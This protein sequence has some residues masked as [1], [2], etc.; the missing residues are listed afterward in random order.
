MENRQPYSRYSKQ[1]KLEAIRRVLDEDQPVQE[2]IQDLGIRHRDNV[3]EWIKKY[4]KEGPNAF[5]RS[6]H[7]V[8]KTSNEYS[9]EKQIEEL[10]MEVEALKSYLQMILQG[11]EEKYKAI[12]SLKNLYPID[13]L[14]SALDVPKV[15]FLEYRQRSLNN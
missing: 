3:Y 2:V 6:I 13:A 1:I 8:E 4:K 9:V 15:E 7:H 5:E 12:E 14:C 11:E 10:K